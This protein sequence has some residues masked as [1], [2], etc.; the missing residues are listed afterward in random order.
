MGSFPS[1]DLHDG[2]LLGRY[3]SSSSFP[4][5]PV[6]RALVAAA[7]ELVGIV[8][9]ICPVSVWHGTLFEWIAQ[10]MLTHFNLCIECA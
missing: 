10:W 1:R 4:L 7:L 9:C 2:S 6:A 5:L 8:V 3:F